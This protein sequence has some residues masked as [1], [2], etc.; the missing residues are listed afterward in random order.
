M[1][2]ASL[3]RPPVGDACEVFGK[4]IAGSPLVLPV[5]WCMVPVFCVKKWVEKPGVGSKHAA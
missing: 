5:S 1:L 4:T 3:P 2:M